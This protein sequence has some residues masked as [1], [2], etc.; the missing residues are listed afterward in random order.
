MRR[1]DAAEQAAELQRLATRLLEIRRAEER[2]IRDFQACIDSTS[3]LLEPIS[4]HK[5]GPAEGS[6]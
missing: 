6:S 2:L 5:N 4:E 1:H 3:R